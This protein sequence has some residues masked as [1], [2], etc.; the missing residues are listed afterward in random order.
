MVRV[1]VFH[2][3]FVASLLAIAWTFG[4]H[5]LET[6]ALNTAIAYA[7][8]LYAVASVT[9]FAATLRAIA[10]HQDGADHPSVAGQA[11]LRNLKCGPIQRLIFGCYGFAEHATHHRHPAIPSYRLVEA[12]IE[13][14]SHTPDLIPQF[15][16]GQILLAQS[17]GAHAP[18]AGETPHGNHR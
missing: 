8:S 10:E 16:Y 7:I 3:V 2:G 17:F 4:S 14:A 13:L 18:I 5:D 9:L 12:T 1:V 11:A 6:A 15:S